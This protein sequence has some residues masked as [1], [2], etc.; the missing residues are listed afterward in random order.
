[1][2]RHLVRSVFAYQKQAAARSPAAAT[3]PQPWNPGD[4]TDD[5]LAKHFKPAALSRLQER[6]GQGLLVELV[7]GPKPSA[8]FHD[9]PCLIRFLVPGDPRYTHCDCAESAPC[10]HVPLAVWAFRRLEAS[11][12]ARMIATEAQLLPIPADILDEA[13]A[14]LLAWTEVGLAGASAVWKDRLTQLEKRCRTAGLV[15]P[16][17]ILAELRQQ[18]ER[19]LSH[20]ALFQPLRV[21]E[22]IGE[23]LIRADA[24]RRPTGAVPQL[25]IRGAASD[26]PLEI[27]SARYIG[28][29]CDA[30]LRK[31]SVELAAIFKM[32][33][34]A[35]WWRL[36]AISSIRKRKSQS[37]WRAWPK[38]RC[39][40]ALIFANWAPARCWFK[41]A[42]ATPTIAWLWAGPRPG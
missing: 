33:T 19:Y 1:M 23:F 3:A 8:Y 39:S 13:E 15:W 32:Q 40:K 2:C 12:P 25:F 36:P 24:I 16:A 28:L 41:A 18:F 9:Q 38:R 26:E 37:R 31:R 27:G 10:S 14:A 6:F 21:P 5:Q 35:V 4:L 7:R 17:E 29:G 20:D 42:S 11:A 22:L 30:A 34:A